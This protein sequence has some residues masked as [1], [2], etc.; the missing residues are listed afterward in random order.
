MPIGEG[1]KKVTIRD[2]AQSFAAPQVQVVKV[3]DR[4]CAKDIGH[5]MS[6]VLDLTE[7]WVGVSS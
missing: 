1:M 2:K 6:E 7:G 3:D 4:A 5:L